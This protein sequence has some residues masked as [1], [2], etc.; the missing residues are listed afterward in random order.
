[1]NTFQVRGARGY[2]W[3]WPVGCLFL[4]GT[5]YIV[6]EF[7]GTF[8]QRAGG[9]SV[10]NPLVGGLLLSAYLPIWGLFA[11]LAI[12]GLLVAIGGLPRASQA[13]NAVL[14]S[15]LLVAM[16]TQVASTYWAS[17]YM[18]LLITPQLSK[19]VVAV[20]VAGFVVMVSPRLGRSFAKTSLFLAVAWSLWLVLNQMPGYV[21][22]PG[23][24][25]E[26]LLVAMA[27]LA[28]A[29]SLVAGGLALTANGQNAKL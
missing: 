12:F 1:M 23:G 20:A 18:A 15:G 8:I 24:P 11:A 27:V 5:G 4:F 28:G 21:L 6:A 25:T 22:S 26:P 16:A 17:K 2:E 19:A 13:A 14:V 10:T 3:I 29:Y 9:I 7:L